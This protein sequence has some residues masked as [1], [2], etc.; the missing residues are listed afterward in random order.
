MSDKIISKL[1]ENDGFISV[2]DKSS[3]D[4]IYQ[5][6]GASKKTYKKAVGALYKKRVISLEEEGIRL[7][8]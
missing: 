7:K 8:G 2:T 1:K 6:F 4:V 5:L 3:P